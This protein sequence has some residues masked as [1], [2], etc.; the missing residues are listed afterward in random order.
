MK[1]TERTSSTECY[2]FVVDTET[3]AGG[4]ECEVVAHMTGEVGE[5]GVGKAIA[6][7]ARLDMKQTED[8]RLARRWLR[9][10]VISRPDENGHRRPASIYPTPGWLNDGHGGA[11][12]ESEISAH[13]VAERYIAT[14]KAYY[15]P[16]RERA[17]K[18]A[19]DE[20]DKGNADS[21]TRWRAEAARHTEAIAD[22][23]S[24]GPG[25][26]P[27]YQSA[28]VWLDK[29]PPAGVSLVLKKRATGFFATKRKWSGPVTVTGF[30]VIKIVETH[31][32]RNV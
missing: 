1:R 4:F 25:Q 17:L 11:Y 16:H 10:H 12:R 32:S 2:G 15:E 18:N 31:R 6:K 26:F 29:N 23:E 19:A 30:R 21:A 7:A 20:E 5:C 14:V 28:V 13:W 9:R 24:R 22:A 27:S 8:Q 3:F